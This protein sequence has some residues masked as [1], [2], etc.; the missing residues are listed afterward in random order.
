MEQIE[1]LT[2]RWHTGSND[3]FGLGYGVVVINRSLYVLQNMVITA[4]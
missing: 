1:D 4:G 3:L 2:G